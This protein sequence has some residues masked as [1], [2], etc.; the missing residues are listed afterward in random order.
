MKTGLHWYKVAPG[1]GADSREWVEYIRSIQRDVLMDIIHCAE[2][3]GTLEDVVEIAR[4]AV[5]K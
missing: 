3:G 4:K 2:S 1:Y 5:G